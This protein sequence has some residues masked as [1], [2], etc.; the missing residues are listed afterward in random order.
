MEYLNVKIWKIPGLVA[1]DDFYFTSSAL[2]CWKDVTGH[3]S[4]RV[5]IRVNPLT[6]KSGQVKRNLGVNLNLTVT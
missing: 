1:L 4:M 2:L 3:L 5:R 6:A